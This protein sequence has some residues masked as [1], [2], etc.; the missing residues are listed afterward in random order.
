[1]VRRIIDFI[2]DYL[3]LLV[4]IVIAAVWPFLWGLSR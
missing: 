2:D 4:F 1:M 3:P